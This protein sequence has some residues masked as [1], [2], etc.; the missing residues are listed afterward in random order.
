MKTYIQPGYQ[1]ARLLTSL[2]QL[3]NF[4]GL[5][6][7]FIISSTLMLAV[8]WSIFMVYW[9]VLHCFSLI[10]MFYSPSPQLLWV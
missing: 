10:A 1:L 4:D 8:D 2:I 9:T 5:I 3:R 7:Y 6:N